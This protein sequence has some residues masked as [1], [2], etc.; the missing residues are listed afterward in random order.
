MKIKGLQKT[1]LIDYPDKVGCTIFLFGCN[2]KC[3]FCHNPELVLKDDEETGEYSEEDILEFL[4]KRKAHLEGICI[5]GG[6]PLL[7]LD[8]GFLKKIKALGY[9]IKLDTNGSF[10]DKL[11]QLIDEKLVDFVS[12]DIKTS[13]ENY[14]EITNS[15]VDLKK[16]EK[17]I[18]IISSLEDYEFR[19]TV[20]EGHHSVEVFESIMDWFDKLFGVSHDNKIKRFSLQGFKNKGKLIDKSYLRFFDTS[21][22]YLQKLK[23]VIDPY[24][25]KVRVLV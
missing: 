6:E 17:S 24:V 19:T 25:E 5:T 12:M 11:K 15:N 22:D 16:I 3:G 20:L 7:T 4:E 1:T 14:S 9:L 23:R 13:K 21:D 2:F 18:K 8:P 10:P